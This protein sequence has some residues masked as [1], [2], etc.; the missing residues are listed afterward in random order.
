MKAAFALVLMIG[1]GVSACSTSVPAADLPALAMPLAQ[2]IPALT[3]AGFSCHLNDGEQPFYVCRDK[4]MSAEPMSAFISVDVA[5]GIDISATGTCFP[6]GA[7]TLDKY[8]GLAYP[9]LLAKGFEA[10]WVPSNDQMADVSAIPAVTKEASS[11]MAALGKILGL[12]P[13]TIAA[14]CGVDIPVGAGQ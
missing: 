14:A 12:Q 9:V 11:P 7:P 13:T 4:N 6:D 8:P 10:S 2:V 5:N 3:A 1:L